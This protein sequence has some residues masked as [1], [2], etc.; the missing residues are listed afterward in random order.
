MNGNQSNFRPCSYGVDA[1]WSN[2]TISKYG[3]RNPSIHTAL[4]C[5][6]TGRRRLFCRK[7]AVGGDNGDNISFSGRRHRTTS[8]S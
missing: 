7:P 2:I 8:N 5:S 6:V 3:Y 1:R 4:N